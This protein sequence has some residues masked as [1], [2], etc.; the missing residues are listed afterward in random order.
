MRALALACIMAVTASPAL[1]APWVRGFV[2][3]QYEPAF[4]Y[5]AKAGT[6]EAGTDCPK[7]TTPDN[8]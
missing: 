3:D 8:D 4:Y 1:A 2:V 5:G 6:M 7:G